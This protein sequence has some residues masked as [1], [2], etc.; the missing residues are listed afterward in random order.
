V[1]TIRQLPV[2]RRL[3]RMGE[4][5]GEDRL[6]EYGELANEMEDAFTALNGDQTTDAS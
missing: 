3:L 2:M 1:E 5:L 6:E 4:D